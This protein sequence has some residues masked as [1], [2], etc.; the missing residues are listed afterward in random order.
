[1]NFISLGVTDLALASLLIIINGALSLVL[2]L[3]LERQL[4]I[5]ACRMVVQLSLVG[6]VLKT[7]FAMVS[8][9][10]TAVA[11]LVMVLFAGYEASARQRR[12]L[13]GWWTYEIGTSSMMAAGIVVTVLALT[14]QIKPDLWCD[15]RYA[16]P[17]FGWSLVIPRVA[18]R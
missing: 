17:L 15:P 4:I 10:W 3:G 6:I 16:L 13:L 8:P 1:M 12:K 18:L 5:S 14:T 2:G 9:F 7:L 11:A